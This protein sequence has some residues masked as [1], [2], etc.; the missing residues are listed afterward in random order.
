M[1]AKGEQI[2]RLTQEIAASQEEMGKM[3][4]EISDAT[5]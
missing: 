1:K 3:K 2:A 5:K 4:A